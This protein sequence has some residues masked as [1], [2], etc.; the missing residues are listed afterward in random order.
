TMLHQK[1]NDPNI[2][3]EVVL[4]LGAIGDRTTVPLLIESYPEDDV[5]GKDADEARWM[6]TIC[7]TFA[8]TYLTGEPIGRSRW[9]ADCNPKNRQL[10]REWWQRTAKPSRFQQRSPKRPGFPTIRRRKAT[11]V[12]REGLMKWCL[13]LEDMGKAEGARAIEPLC[14]LWWFP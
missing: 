10:W 7:F 9:G 12:R 8:L 14:M 2:Q 11:Q 1:L 4:V 3:N 13:G 6:R 5:R